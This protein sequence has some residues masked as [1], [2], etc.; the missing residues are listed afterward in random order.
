MVDDEIGADDD[1][2]QHQH[3]QRQQVPWTEQIITMVML[4][5]IGELQLAQGLRAE[6]E[7]RQDG[8]RGRNQRRR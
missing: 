6:S 8:R 4:R 5:K 7:Q 1:H 3:D 2:Q